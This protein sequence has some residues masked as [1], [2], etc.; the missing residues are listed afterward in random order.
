MLTHKCVHRKQ[1]TIK[2]IK[3][4]VWFNTIIH[5]LQ[6]LITIN[7]TCF[8]I[9]LQFLT[10][11]NPLTLK[12][13]SNEPLYSNTLIG[14][15]AIDKWAVMFHTARRGLQAVDTP[16]PLLTVPNVT[17]HPS[18]ASEPTSYYS[19]WRYNYFCNLKG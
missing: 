1:H 8:I 19:M 3:S 15:W 11:V 16:S 2:F 12:P 13:Q 14:T 18:T 10:T 9:E 4:A 7:D 5:A 17:A 6:K